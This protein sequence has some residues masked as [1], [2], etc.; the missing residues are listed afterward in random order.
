M[1]TPK[2]E[3]KR[4]I[5]RP[6]KYREEYCEDLYE[7]MSE[8]FSF[9]SFGG[10][11][12]VDE[13]T[14]HEWCKKHKEFDKSKK[15]GYQAGLYAY[16]KLV[17]GHMNGTIEGSASALVWFGKNVHNWKDKKEVDLNSGEIK[18]NITKEDS[19]L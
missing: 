17:T 1:G 14:M 3:T 2:K 12:R 18:I 19:K 4:K 9:K 15:E 13:A 6:T 11:I 8:G 16:E 7:H 10:R 5:G